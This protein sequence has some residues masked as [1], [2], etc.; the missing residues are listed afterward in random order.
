[1]EMDGVLDLVRLLDGDTEGVLDRV[2]D[3]VLDGV[4]EDDGDLEGVTD[5]VAVPDRVIVELNDEPPDAVPVLL[6]VL[7]GVLLVV[8][9]LPQGKRW[10]HQIQLRIHKFQRQCNQPSS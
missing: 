10:F 2:P 9:Y 8:E 5:D 6:G 7:L 3:R 1:M 4:T